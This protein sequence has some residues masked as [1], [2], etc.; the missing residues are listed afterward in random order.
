MKGKRLVSM[1][2]ALVLLLGLVPVLGAGVLGAELSGE[3]GG[4]GQWKLDRSTG[5]LT[6]SGGGDLICNRGNRA[7]WAIWAE[8]IRWIIVEEGITTI[9]MGAF[10][11]CQWTEKITI[12]STMEE[13]TYPASRYLSAFYVAESNETFTQLDGV[14]FSEDLKTL[15][16]LPGGYRGC[17]TVPDT[18]TDIEDG[19]FKGCHTLMEVILP[20]S[21]AEIKTGVFMDCTSLISVTLPEG[22]KIIR[23]NAFKNCRSLEKIHLP[24]GLTTLEY[25]AF[26]GT[27]L[28]EVRIP[29]SVVKY[30][31]AFQNCYQ[32]ESLT[33][34]KGVL[35][36]LETDYIYTPALKKVTVSTANPAYYCDE[37]GVLY[38]KER[39]TL[40]AAPLALGGEYAVLPG[41]EII[42]SGAFRG[43]Y[44]LTAVQL[45]DTLNSIADQ[46]F[47]RCSALTSVN[48]PSAV[49]WI[50]LAAFD[51]CRGLKE[52]QL[53]NTMQYLGE[54]AFAGTG[55]TEVAIPE[56]Y[57]ELPEALFYGCKD[58]EK[59]ELPCSLK[60]IGA[61]AFADCTSLHTLSVPGKETAASLRAFGSLRELKISPE[62]ENFALDSVGAVYNR[63]M[64]E[65]YLVP[66]S[67]EGTFTIA[68]T[69]GYISK[70][71]FTE[72]TFHTLEIPKELVEYEIL[73]GAYGTNLKKYAVEEDHPAFSVDW[74][75][76][77]YNK[78]QTHLLKLPA[79]SQGAYQ[80]PEQLVSWDTYAFTGCEG[81]TE[82]HV[83]KQLA[84]L[85][86]MSFD[87]D[88]LPKLLVSEDHPRC[89]NDEKGVLY[90]RD[91][92][93]LL[94]APK[95]LKGEYTVAATVGWMDENAFRNCTELTGVNMEECG[96]TSIGE[97]AFSHCTA[98]QWVR[99]PKG[100]KVIHDR[101]FSD[102]SALKTVEL[103]HGLETLKGNAF[104]NCISLGRA[105][106]PETVRD[107]ASAFFNC[108]ALQTVCFMGDIPLN[109]ENSFLY[110]H[111]E[112][113]VDYFLPKITAEYSCDAKGFIAPYCSGIPTRVFSKKARNCTGEDCGCTAY[114]DLPQ[115]GHWAHNAIEE[116]L[117]QGLVNGVGKNRFNPDGTMTRAMLVTILYR[118]EGSPKVWGCPFADVPSDTWYTE[119]VTWASEMGIIKGMGDG[120]FAPNVPVTREQVATILARYL[121]IQE[122]SG[123]DRASLA[124]FADGDSVS[125]Y[126]REAMERMVM[127]GIING[128]GTKLDPR[129]TATR[130]EVATILWRLLEFD[131]SFSP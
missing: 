116:L 28:R 78:E 29:D 51:G 52:I 59:V 17:Y 114:S 113:G 123:R 47:E 74:Q 79:G 48:I 130:A 86:F 106:V 11:A 10:S 128:K 5:T 120:L 67:V 121:G 37:K 76:A 8:E 25:G 110:Y 50:G 129:G 40:L 118:L 62:N 98:L 68:P 63:D 27:G 112:R 23:G 41:V 35:S 117:E 108:T 4:N 13:I 1:L 44:R 103:P 119:S 94:Y 26:T 49:T 18:V 92:T 7:P 97:F 84:D 54:Y 56:G 101:A 91:M 33:V 58:L 73:K 85:D 93:Q 69:C 100:L 46:A 109:F 64:T 6:I 81:L 131:T 126:A 43:C 125:D 124:C 65:L 42:Y 14:L 9:T 55:L 95:D 60:Y 80:G 12:P 61:Q 38:D 82:V 57:T 21:L 104:Y 75:G 45:P 96:V 105:T 16:C 36:H 32:L 3:L 87:P 24:E 53:P 99:F 70:D 115:P 77:L 66:A 19:A 30:G 107:T 89:V 20:E 71:A 90:S 31:G 88:Y 2:L 22:L 72:A 111:E 15:I 102:C 127:K 34:G 83:G 122:G 39:T